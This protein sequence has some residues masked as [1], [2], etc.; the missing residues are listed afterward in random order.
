MVSVNNMVAAASLITTVQVSA[1]QIILIPK[2]QLFTS[3]THSRMMISTS[4]ASSS[5]ML[6]PP[7]RQRRLEPFRQHVR[8]NCVDD[9]TKH[10]LTA[11]EHGEEEGRITREEEQQSPFTPPSSFFNLDE[12]INSFFDSIFAPPLPPQQKRADDGVERYEEDDPFDSVIRQMLGF[13][14]RAFDDI[15]TTSVPSSQTRLGNGNTNNMILGQ[16]YD[17]EDSSSSDIEEEVEDEDVIIPQKF[18]LDEDYAIPQ[19]RVEEV[20]PEDVA[21]SA[22]DTLVINLAHRS[23]HRAADGGNNGARE[24]IVLPSLNNLPKLLFDVGNDLLAETHSRRRLMEAEEGSHREVDPHLQ[25][26]ERL[27]KI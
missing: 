25:V 2:S 10:C 5:S 19:E 23:I 16:S 20:S 11:D 8:D 18:K 21:V 9:A 1:Q 13:S 4:P 17:N 12:E 26:K 7:C 6:E 24:D 15:M 22:M 3:P 14:L 27:G